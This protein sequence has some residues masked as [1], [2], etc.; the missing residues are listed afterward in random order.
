MTR[1]PKSKRSSAKKTPAK[2]ARRVAAPARKAAKK[3]GAPR[4]KAAKS[5]RTSRT[6][7]TRAQSARDRKE[8]P[9]A[10]G[11]R[12]VVQNVNVPGYTT[13][14]DAPKYHAMK[15]ALL[16]VLPSSGPGLTQAEMMAAVKPHLPQTLFPGGAKSE[17]WT[18]GVQLD[19]EAKGIVTRSATK[20]LRWTRG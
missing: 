7:A 19:L 9:G 8:T 4:A 6:R 13:T 20:P 5:P 17:W 16:K 12:V 18:K 10:T 11:G 1:A 15:D 14:L 3:K 2:T